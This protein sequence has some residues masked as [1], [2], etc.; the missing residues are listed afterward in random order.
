[1]SVGGDGYVVAMS[2]CA[3]RDCKQQL[4]VEN[5]STDSP[6]FC[7]ICGDFVWAFRPDSE[8]PNDWYVVCQTTTPLEHLKVDGG[9][10]PECG[11][12]EY[13][14]EK[15]DRWTWVAVCAGQHWDGDD[16]EGCGTKYPVRQKAAYSVIF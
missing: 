10:C 3:N 12:S 16:L 4:T 6:S 5:R 2:V 1:M 14:V 9:Q 15:L 7:R 13:R 11:L 8:Q